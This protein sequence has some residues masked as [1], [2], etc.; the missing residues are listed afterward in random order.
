MPTPH[1]SD[2]LYEDALA[3]F[4]RHWDGTPEDGLV[5]PAL[6]AAV[7]GVITDIENERGPL[8][9]ERAATLRRRLVH[10]VCGLGP[11]S[12][13]IDDPLVTEVLIN[14]PHD[15]FVE[16][17]GV[18]NPVELA[19]TMQDLR[20]MIGRMLPFALGRRLDASTPYVD[21]SLPGGMRVNIVIPPIV[22]GGP[23]VTIRKHVPSLRTL[24]DL[25]ERGMIDTSAQEWLLGAVDVHANVLISG[26]SGSGKT[27]LLDKLTARFDPH[28]RIVTIEDTLEL[29]VPKPDVVRLLTRGANVE[30][31][32]EVSIGD[33]FRNALR[34]HPTR[35][36]LGE[37]RGREAL[38]YL[39]AINS[40]HRGT[41][42]VIHAATPEEALIRLEHLV[43]HVGLPIASR[44]LRAQMSHGL[45]AVVQVTQLPDGTRRVTRISEIAGILPDGEVDLRDVY[46]WET[47]GMGADGH[48]QGA[49][50]VVGPSRVAARFALAGAPMPE[51]VVPAA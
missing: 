31:K 11:V 26:A 48:L 10:H 51:G 9:E 2:A 36:L 34:M 47:T 7:Q 15:V 43:A 49:L 3:R 27:T 20:A 8:G 38:D 24:D 44:V 37:I 33:L 46:R 5:E 4:A 14:G 28:E 32:G 29:H 13:W 16:R 12:H 40:G 30:G 42:A 39:A 1:P 23:H 25:R 45:D 35:I 41:F 17:E 50:R 22:L 18:T 19:L 21:L 6:D